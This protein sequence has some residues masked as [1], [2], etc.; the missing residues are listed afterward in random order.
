MKTPRFLPWLCVVMA[1]IASVEFTPAN[2]APNGA[3]LDASHASI[4]AAI[5]VQNKVSRELMAQPAVLGTAVG[6]D[7]ANEIVLIVYLDRENP[8]LAAAAGAVPVRMGGMNVRL[9]VTEKFRAFAGRGGGGGGGV[10]VSHKSKQ[11]PPIQLGVSGGWR[12]DL[13]NGFCCGGTL[14]GLIQVHG[15]AYILSNY[16]A[17]E[18]DIIPG[19]NGTFS[20]TGDPVIHPGL[21][22]I[23]CNAS[24]ALN[25][26][27]LVKLSALPSANV[28][29]SIAQ[30]VPG[31]VSA[32][33]S[34]LQIG[35]LSSAT[36]APALRQGVKKSGR[37]TGLTSSSI[38]GLN[39]SVTIAYENEC[40]GGQAFTKWFTGLIVMN[41]KGSRFLNYGDSGSIMV[42]NTA[43][44]P[45][46]IGLLF[47]GSSS[48]ALA[49]PMDEVLTL[50][51][52]R[53][54]GIATMVGNC[55]DSSE[56]P[57]AP[58]A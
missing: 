52:S 20:G 21:I 57:A 28:D 43:T 38:V 9:E 42:E 23:S 33:G 11:N 31:M 13:A 41:N 39:A 55:A 54:G 37:T 45:R 49:H 7:E 25:V 36:L 35:T 40:V 50:V 5:A 46:A 30:V 17:F 27:S 2:E 14:G 58:D 53:L 44:N 47:A 6:T 19:G 34:I 1:W 29:C 8:G 22:D 51:G 4:Q 12:D 16:H 15:V 3:A 48:T 24:A 56:R 32:T 18:A 26:A 10:G